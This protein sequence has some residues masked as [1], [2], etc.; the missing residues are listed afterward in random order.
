MADV[1]GLVCAVV[2]QLQAEA[3]ERRQLEEMSEDEYDALPDVA[4][5]EV[6]RKR[7]EIKKERLAR[8]KQSLVTMPKH[9]NY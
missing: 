9:L 6:D 2:R 4:K 7:L 5:A 8:F 3:T 1:I